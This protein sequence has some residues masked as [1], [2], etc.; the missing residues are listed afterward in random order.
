M[1]EVIRAYQQCCATAI[2]AYDGYVAKY[3]GDGVLAYFG[4][5][6]A[7]EDDA[8]RAVRAGLEL[9]AAVGRI[10]TPHSALLQVRIGIASG[11]VVVGDLIGEGASQERAVVGDTP[12]QAARLQS[13]AEPGAIVVAASTRQLLG[14]IFELHDLGRHLV[15]GFKAPIEAWAIKGARNWESR[16]EARATALTGFT[17]RKKRGGGKAR[18]LSFRARPASASRAS[19]DGFPNTWRPNRIFGCDINAR[20]TMPTARFT[21]SLCSSDRLPELKPTICPMPSSTSSRRC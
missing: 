19:A 7:H 21:R 2:A 6:H 15:K 8:E 11:L 18:S 12:N 20:P 16:F 14:N 13:L 5:P 10:Q 17:A 9:V 3:L 1:R 4:Y